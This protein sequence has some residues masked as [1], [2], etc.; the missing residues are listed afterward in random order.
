[1][2]GS[3]AFQYAV[4]PGGSLSRVMCKLLA[5]LLPRRAAAGFSQPFTG[6]TNL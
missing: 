2:P 6:F 1:M 3:S 5:T 4:C